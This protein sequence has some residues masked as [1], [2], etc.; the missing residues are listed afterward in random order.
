MSGT[1]PVLYTIPTWPMLPVV[2]RGGSE[3][4]ERWYHQGRHLQKKNTFRDVV[5]V[6]EWLIDQGYT[7]RHLLSG[8]GISAGGLALGI[9]TR[10]MMPTPHQRPYFVRC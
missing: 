4:G 5:S 8:L 10:H 9:A 7:S 3:L 1:P 6:A 2:Y